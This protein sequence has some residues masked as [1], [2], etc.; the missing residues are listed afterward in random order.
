M[1][2]GTGTGERHAS[3]LELFF[4][5]VAV[6]GVAQLSHLVHTTRSW[7]D[8]GLYV[9]CFLA[10]WTAWM[11]FTVYGNVAGGATRVAPVFGA[12]LGLAIMAAA[13]EGVGGEH[14]R[15]FAIAYVTV[16]VLADRVWQSRD[17]RRIVVDWP[18]VQVG[19]GVVPW[20]VS[21]W[22]EAPWRYVLWALGLALDLVITFLF[23]GKRAVAGF[24][25]RSEQ[26]RGSRPVP[27]AQLV[28]LDAAHIGERLGLFMIIVLGEGVL[29][30]TEAMTA[31]E[32]W[33]T[34]LYR[35]VF[36]ALALLAA[37]WAVMLRHGSGGVP[38]LGGHA[39]PAR[40]MLPLHCL[41]AGVVVALASGLGDVI[42]H[43]PPPAGTRWLLC[44]A[45]AAL[46]LLGS[47]MGLVAGRGGWWALA[48]ASIAVA[49]PGLV[50]WLGAEGSAVVWLLVLVVVAQV[51]V[52][53]FQLRVT[54]Q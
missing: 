54:R 42:G 24:S 50:G 15:T 18:A 52:T 22:A 14:A 40:V 44:G 29:V 49:G 46:G 6:A 3:W 47:V 8:A 23:A 12:M 20:I 32:H 13:V 31:T 19:S 34:P 11:C 37:L 9:V 51:A 45:V 36:G 27:Q 7:G 2:E 41:T 21:L 38:F 48:V 33:A 30:V 10:F 25:R 4:D 28:H 1:T 5:L 17:V 43:G 26:H 53:R 35:T 39:L 16:R